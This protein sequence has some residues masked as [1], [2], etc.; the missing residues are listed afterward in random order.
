MIKDFYKNFNRLLARVLF[1]ATL[2][3][4]KVLPYCFIRAFARFIILGVFY[5]TNSRLFK[6]AW[7]GINLAFG[8]QKSLVEKE[9]LVKQTF[10]NLALVI[11]EGIYYF[12]H[13]E[14]F[15]ATAI[16]EGE[17]HL[18]NALQGQKGVVVITAHLGNFPLM[19]GLLSRRGYK[20]NVLMRPPRDKKMGKFIAEKF[21][22]FGGKVIFTVP[23]RACIQKSIRALR[24]NELLF[25]L[26]DQNYGA[27]ARVFVD[28]FGAKAAT[29]ASPLAFAWRTGASVLPIFSVRTDEGNM[30]IIIDLEIDIERSDKS[31]ASMKDQVQMLML[32]IEKY[33]SK[34]PELWSWMHDRW[35]SKETR[36][37]IGDPEILSSAKLKT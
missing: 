33:V 10:E 17:E 28:F 35:K 22:S 18:K 15:E 14:I 21:S 19:L 32:V 16:I 36:V 25:I 12:N 6:N 8:D 20:V 24:S 31:A 9:T 30:K 1:S 34:Y 29:G 2:F 4:A 5:K 23:E 27:G 11:A 26:I 13:P 3:F 7:R 37:E